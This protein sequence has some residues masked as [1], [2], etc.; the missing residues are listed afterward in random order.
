MRL[1]A[2]GLL[3]R[4]GAPTGGPPPPDCS[5]SAAPRSRCSPAA[6][7]PAAC[8]GRAPGRARRPRRRQPT[9]AAGR[10]GTIDRLVANAGV[11]LPGPI[12]EGRAAEWPRLLDEVIAFVAARCGTQPQ[13]PG[14]SAE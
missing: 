14:R 11:M 5:R 12:E 7:A 8:G 6:G 3:A 1:A 10:V 4:R 13:P 2:V 9:R